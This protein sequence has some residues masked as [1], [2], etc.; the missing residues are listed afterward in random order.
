[1][2][3]S[4]AAGPRCGFCGELPPGRLAAKG[5]PAVA[6]CPACRVWARVAL[7]EDLLG[8]LRC[9]FCQRLRRVGGMTAIAQSLHEPGVGIC[10][11]CLDFCDEFTDE[12]LYGMES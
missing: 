7:R 10:N 8:G 4:S 2:A 5:P 1:M 6:I 3:S 12:E 9:G 11:E